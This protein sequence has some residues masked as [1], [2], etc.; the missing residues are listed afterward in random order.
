MSDVD[1]TPA[2]GVLSPGVRLAAMPPGGEAG[3]L[4]ASRLAGRRIAT[5]DRTGDER[6]IRRH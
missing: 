6:R 5:G 4:F 1:A 2:D 3:G